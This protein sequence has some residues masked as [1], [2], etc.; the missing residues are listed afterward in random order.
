MPSHVQVVP[1]V[2]GSSSL[3][4]VVRNDVCLPEEFIEQLHQTNVLHAER[5]TRFLVHI[6]RQS[7]VRQSLL[8]PELPEKG[9]FAMYNHK[10]RPGEHYNPSR[11]LCRYVGSTSNILL[12]GSGFVKTINE[13]IQS[14]RMAYAEAL[15]LSTLGK[16]LDSRI[17]EGDIAV[18][19]SSLVPASYTSLLF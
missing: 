15:F 4:A 8:R 9:I 14:N 7:H 18:H 3:Y 13:P 1:W 6:L 16:E 17:E 12:L 5:L 11:L 19:G 2:E 10:E